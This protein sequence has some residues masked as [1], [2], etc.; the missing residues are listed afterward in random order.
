MN[1][2]QLAAGIDVRSISQPK[3]DLTGCRFTGQFAGGALLANA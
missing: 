3:R 1:N 2:F